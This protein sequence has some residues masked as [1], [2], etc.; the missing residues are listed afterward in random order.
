MPDPVSIKDR[1]LDNAAYICHRC[2]S[3]NGGVWPA[4]HVATM[5][6]GKCDICG[7]HA[8]LA[9]TGDWNWRDGKTRGMRD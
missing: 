7:E 8:S 4:G 2:A 6:A 1:S 3:A 5:H 9:S